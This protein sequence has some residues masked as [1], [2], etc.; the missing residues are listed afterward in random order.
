[1]STP[2]SYPYSLL[3]RARQARGLSQR[4]VAEVVGT[5][6]FTVTRWELGTAFPS[7]HFRQRL[8]EL[9]GLSAD[10][11]G[12]LQEAEAPPVSPPPL[13]LVPYQRNPCFTGREEILAQLHVQL[14]RNHAAALTQALALSGLGGIGKTQTALEYVYRYAPA[15][16]AVFWLAAETQESLLTSFADLAD[17]VNLPERHEPDQQ[18]MVSAVSHWLTTHPG[19]L[20]IVDNAEDLAL[21]QRW[22][23]TA[24][25]GT[26]LITTRLR[27]L[28]TLAEPLELDRLPVEE[29]ARLLLRRAKRLAPEEAL[30]AVPLE[31]RRVAHAIADTLGGLPLA[32]D[33]AG[34]YLE[35][36]GCRLADYLER[37]H[38]QR[39]HLL[40]RRG[41]S[42]TEHPQSVFATFQL[43]RQRLE[44]ECPAAS[45]LLQVCASL[46]AEAIP[47]ELFAEGVPHLSDVLASVVGDPLQVDLALAA[48]RRFSLV[49]RQ[50]ET[51]TFSLH[52]LVQAVVQEDLSAPERTQGQKDALRLLAAHFPKV[53]TYANWRQCARLLP[54]ILTSAAILPEQGL[55]TDV[56]EL[57]SKAADYLRTQAQYEVAEPLYQQAM[58]LGEQTVGPE[59]PTVATLLNGLASLYR[60]WGRYQEA[61]PLF[62]RVWRIREQA[63]GPDHFLVAAPLNNLA[64]LYQDRGQY[65]EALPLFERALAIFEQ[66]LGSDHPTL[67]HSLH[68]LA[69]LHADLGHYSESLLLYERALAILE[70]ALGPDHPDVAT[71]LNAL[72]ECYRA[73]GQNAQAFPLYKRALAISEQALGPKHP[74]VANY[75][76]NLAD[77]ARTQGQEMQALPLYKR[78]LAI[79]EHALGPDH[80]DVAT[81]LSNLAE[82]SSALGQPQEALPLIQR[83]LAIQEHAL[84]LDHPMMAQSL[85][86][87]AGIYRDQDQDHEALALY[88]QALA[89]WER[90]LGPTHQQVAHGLNS[91][92]TLY[93]HQGHYQ[94]ALPL[95]RRALAILEQA[96]G[97]E[98]P[99]VA[100]CLSLL[101]GLLDQLGTPE[102]ARFLEARVQGI[103]RKPPRVPR[104]VRQHWEHS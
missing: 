87:L 99:D 8:M 42:A 18:R 16:S 24:R 33:Q 43:A 58:R 22:L 1:M 67:A 76:H 23:P 70:Q 84:G 21:V 100:T 59:H 64:L 61:E 91:L 30:E 38:T 75:L 101:A 3:R 53:P 51:R 72:A 80:P 39:R 98:H 36:T 44:R 19:W 12:L 13:W 54:H 66:T 68:N 83:A 94:E 73:Q 56:A 27:A 86:I 7:P 50:H 90:A 92:A 57:L 32:L 15:Y 37:Y 52:R 47:E 17:V 41:E 103:R 85:S 6:R 88:E 31:E 104:R 45:A 65:Q 49:Q 11:L 71:C 48:L 82:L 25:P 60:E 89:I 62:E 9:F 29:G 4:Q 2:L 55:D 34:A 26:L 14:G 69:R 5:N 20:L 95:A 74:D 40:A 93:Q 81:C 10:A 77:L 78:A 102:Q 79:F 97:P 96:L 63:L 35:E 46:H 28:G